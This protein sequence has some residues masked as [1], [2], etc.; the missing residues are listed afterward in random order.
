MKCPQCKK[1]NLNQANYCQKCGRKF[2]DSEKEA[3]KENFFV[4][5]MERIQ[6]AKDLVTFDFITG[7]PIFKILSVLI[8]LAVGIYMVATKGYQLRVLDSNIYQVEYNQ[9]L[10]TYYVLLPN[11]SKKK[12]VKEVDVLLYVPN[13]IKKLDLAYY[14]EEGKLLQQSQRKKKERYTLTV[15]TE[16]NNYYI[17]SNHQDKKEKVKI[18]VYYGE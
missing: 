17:L 2:T 4:A 16:E 6:L 10:K 12:S 5:V 9:K 3:V 8:V 15:N 11:Q 7:H 1:K 13:R 14:D 18:Y